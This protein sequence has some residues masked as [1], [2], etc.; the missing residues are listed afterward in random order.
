[1]ADYEPTPYQLDLG[2]YRGALL[3]ADAWR[4]KH[5]QHMRGMKA[6]GSS[7]EAIQAYADGHAEEWGRIQAETE[8]LK[9]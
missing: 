6:E 1:M 5:N 4:Q 3:K 8:A 9:P 7:A 2:I